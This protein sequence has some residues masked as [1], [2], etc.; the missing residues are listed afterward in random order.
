MA[1]P[2]RAAR[3]AYAGGCCHC[4]SPTI[5][6]TALTHLRRAAAWL[7]WLLDATR[8]T[9]LNLLFLLLL[10]LLAWYLVLRSSA[11]PPLQDKT[12]LVLALRGP[13]HEQWHG[14]LR[15][16]ALKQARGE[17]MAQVR[18]R[19][20][21][22]ALDA[23]ARD[24]AIAR[25]VLVLDDFAGAGLP[26]LREVAAAIERFKASGKPVVAWGSGYDQ[27]QY[28][29]A[30]HASEVWMHPMGA[31]QIEGFGGHR[32]YYKDALDRFGITAHVL[33]AGQYK[34]AA[35]SFVANA[36]SSQTLESEGL[37]YD[38]LWASYTAG[39]ERAR[40]LPAGSIVAAIDQLPERLAGVGG[41]LAKLALKEKL[42]DA[43]KTRDQL[44]ASLIEQ[45]AKDGPTFRQ[46][47]FEAYLARVKPPTG[48][49]A[50]AVVVAE[51]GIVD[52]QAGGGA[53][54]G[55]ST[56]DLVRRA[57]EDD[58]VKALVLRVDSPG[59]SAFGSELVRRELELTR[60]AGKPVVVS[61]GDVAASGG[62]WIS[63]AADEVIADD[64]TVTG[65]I[66][67]VA[68][69]PSAE[70]ALDK[71]GV[72]TGGHTTS[73]L[74]DAYDLRRGLDPRFAQV[75]QSSIDHV[76]A[77]FTAKVAAA[78]KTTP[79]AIHAVGQ[80]RVWTGAQ[81]RERGL[82]D[83]NGSFGDALAAAASRAGLSDGHRVVYL[84]QQ[85][86][87]VE[88]LLGWLGAG[89]L[90]QLG[91]TAMLDPLATLPGAQALRALQEDLAPL[92]ATG[93]QGAQGRAFAASAHCLC[94]AP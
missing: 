83:R 57:R 59:G 25:A 56:S 28:Y 53:I 29:L 35:E 26:T 75:V 78:R 6:A 43:L 47:P 84:E 50:V 7:W 41:D 44:R 36:P 1:P 52:G 85:P 87:R 40:K 9:L 19:D 11:T 15:E 94:S 89:V 39:V 27:R 8:R 76:Y 58:S 82:V 65:S 93:A 92:L 49:A 4:R 62:Y 72:H 10:V 2:R 22:T 45:G 12:A 64:T 14:S 46:I 60:Q 70:Q 74:V 86:G 88:R 68:L 32:N 38:T 5:A 80:G 30:A 90:A 3:I 66:G 51:G 81:A 20:V 18:L 42:V 54:G 16:N 79:D 17:P 69:L 33:R 63:M 61:M 77:D 73:W 67:V 21:L 71:L 55:L 13:I 91:P 23:A 31:V 48:R 24:P 37:L 34:N